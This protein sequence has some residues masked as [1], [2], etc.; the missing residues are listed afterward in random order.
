MITVEG[1][2]G[3]RADGVSD[4]ALSP[5]HLHHGRVLVQPHADAQALADGQL[6]RLGKGC[7]HERGDGGVPTQAKRSRRR[8][9]ALLYRG[10]DAP[11]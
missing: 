7:K 10:D 11:M 9:P 6:G 2:Q 1:G 4:A 5:C 3:V 8:Q